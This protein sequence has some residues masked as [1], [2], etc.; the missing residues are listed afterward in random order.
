M[1]KYIILILALAVGTFLRLW[2][3]SSVP[4]GLTWD[5]AAIGYNAYSILKTGRDEHGAFLPLVFKSFGDYKPGAYIYLT[6]PSVAIFGLNEFA[7][8]FPSALAG[9]IAIL[10]IYL[11]TKEIFSS[12]PSLRAKRGNPDKH[13]ILSEVEESHS[14]NL[15]GVKIYLWDFTALA[16]AISPWSVH[17]SHGAWEVNVFVTLTIF[18]LYFFLRFIKQ[19]ST[20]YPS[21]LFACLSLAMYQAAKLL[22]PLVFLLFVVLYWKDFWQQIS[23]YLSFKKLL[24]VAP[25]ALFGAWIFFGSIFGSAGNRLSTLSIFNYKPD[26]AKMAAPIDGQS[27]FTPI[28]HNQ[29][30]LSLSLILSRYTYHFSPEVLF[31]EG[32]VVSERG[33]MPGLGALNPLE[34]IW[35]IFGFIW[36]AK[37]VAEGSHDT[38]SRSTLTIIG[39]LLIAPIP[40]SLTLAEFSTVRALF[41]SVPLAIISGIGLYYS[42]RQLKF[43]ALPIIIFYGLVT[44]YTFDLYYSH[45]QT[46]FATEFNYGYKQVV[47]LIKD[48]PTDKVIFTDVFG[49]PYIY[50]LFYTAYD[51]TTY[52]KNNKF[53]DGG[54]DVGRVAS[55]GN[56]EFR[57]FSGPDILTQKNT[58]FIGSEGNINNLFNIADP[59]VEL[60]RQIETPDRKILFRVIKTKSE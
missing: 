53:I 26:L 29:T 55:I 10:G 9:I 16:F 46:V 31:Y 49:Q 15:F 32:P 44:V 60:F 39:L 35:L 58:L 43:L 51:P 12:S 34:I 17:F 2:T 42:L 4:S 11:L 19:K 47:Q 18:A 56:V 5:E 57:Q 37:Q 7:V 24:L 20:L 54:L 8:R 25:F 38:P 3:I 27:Q 52:Q 33:H 48:N 21:L 14:I 36:L 59:V 28:F 50:Y 13:V 30:Q 40:A 23:T 6:V 1:K 45:S 22:T 41:M